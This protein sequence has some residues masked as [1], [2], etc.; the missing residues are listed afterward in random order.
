[1]A[2]VIDLT[3]Y[4]KQ[5]DQEE[6]DILSSRLAQMIEELG[7]TNEFESYMETSEDYVYGMPFVFTMFPQLPETNQVTTLSD[8]TD[9]LTTM[10][11]KLDEMGYTKWA[12]DISRIVG[13]MFVSGSS[14]N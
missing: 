3:K 10:T 8:V 6:I 11:L 7:I 9:V 4:L 2:E 12:D 1:M 14:K 5:K 13:E